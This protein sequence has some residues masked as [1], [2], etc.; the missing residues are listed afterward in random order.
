MCSSH[1]GTRALVGKAFRQGFYWPSAVADAHEIVTTCPNCQKHIQ[2][3]K[4]PPE[5][6]C[7]IPP[8][9]PLSQWG[10]DIVGPLSTAPGNYRFAAMAAEYFTKWVEAKALRD[11][12]AG[13]LQKFFWQNIVCRF[14]VPREITL[15]MAN[16]LTQQP[17]GHSASS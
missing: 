14:G 17:F 1:I 7:L 5:V 6:V 3:S 4:F 10:I 9:W 12:S 13:A 8:I 2:Y 16:S 11:I 15:D